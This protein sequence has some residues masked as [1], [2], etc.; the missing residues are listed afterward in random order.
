MGCGAFVAQ[1]REVEEQPEAPPESPAERSMVTCIATT[2]TTITKVATVATAAAYMP[3]YQH[4]DFIRHMG[5]TLGLTAQ[6][7]LSLLDAEIPPTD[8]P[9]MSFA[10]WQSAG[11]AAATQ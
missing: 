5:A 4:A 9:S 3:I 2:V 11:V 10:E 8:M 1:P 6:S 7:T